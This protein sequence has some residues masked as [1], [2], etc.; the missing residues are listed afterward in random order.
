MTASYDTNSI[1]VDILHKAEETQ[2]DFVFTTIMRYLDKDTLLDARIISKKILC[3]ALICFKEDHPEE[4]ARL[5]KES[6][7]R[8]SKEVVV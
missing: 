3:R 4:Y 7:D 6:N 8:I 2:D 1:S 5:L